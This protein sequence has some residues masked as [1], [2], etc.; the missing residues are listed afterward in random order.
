MNRSLDGDFLRKCSAMTTLSSLTLLLAQRVKLFPQGEQST[1]DVVI[2]PT[3]SRLAVVGSTPNVSGL[4][5][6]VYVPNLK[7][8][9]LEVDTRVN[10]AAEAVM[11][12]QV[13]GEFMQDL[14]G[15]G[16]IQ[17]VSVSLIVGLNSLNTWAVFKPLV[18]HACGYLRSL[19]LLLSPSL[20]FPPF[21]EFCLTLQWP[22]LEFLE[23]WC[24]G[25][26]ARLHPPPKDLRK[27]FALV[28]PKLTSFNIR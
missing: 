24:P 1:S 7:K 26:F 23:F 15:M 6:R 3:L 19:V 5:R 16:R 27:R 8:I 18:S 25:G 14:I 11:D 21:A 17:A 9:V 22:E 12:A 4:F 13:I 20:L 2:F 10:S 28:C